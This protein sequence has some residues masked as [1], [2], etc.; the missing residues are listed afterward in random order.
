M[1]PWA[2]RVRPF[3]RCQRPSRCVPGGRSVFR[4]FIFAA[5][6][7]LSMSAVRAQVQVATVRTQPW[8]LHESIRREAYASID[9][10]R[11]YLSSRQAAGGL[12]ALETGA[13]SCFPA[14]AF[15]GDSGA[16]MPTLRRALDAAA[17]AVDRSLT[18]MLTSA[19][20]VELARG[21]LLLQV[22]G[23][24][25]DRVVRA[26]RRLSL[27]RLDS[28]DAGEAALLLDVR[29]WEGRTSGDPEWGAV[30]AKTMSMR[31]P[32]VGTV[33]LAGLA[34]LER[35]GVEA[36]RNAALAHLRWLAGHAPVTSEDAWWLVRFLDQLSPAALHD[37]GFPLDW[38]QRVA[39][40]LI[41]RQRRDSRTGFGYWRL[42]G[43]ESDASGDGALRET[44]FAV[45]VLNHVLQE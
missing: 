38:R 16:A 44:T 22:Q 8:G 45:M 15:T 43:D 13:W 40:A 23:F 11:N 28:F 36:A 1:R 2:H 39:D 4:R 41:A 3:R 30:V 19:E 9:R 17:T 27:V 24:R 32:T 37:A 14:M 7:L 31:N 42:P 26:V 35:A 10:G 20:T 29:G 33:A 21:C 34:R 6:L 5:L 12:W 18:R 25:D